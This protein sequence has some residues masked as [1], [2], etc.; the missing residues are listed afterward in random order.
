MNRTRYLLFIFAG[1]LWTYFCLEIGDIR[2]IL[3]LCAINAI[4]KWSC[5]LF[6]IS[7][8]DQD[9]PRVVKWSRREDG[10]ILLEQSLWLAYI[11]WVL[12]GL[13]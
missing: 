7:M 8:A 11:I 1:V 3:V 12:V 2:L 10:I 9:Y 5:R 4:L 13:G 6:F